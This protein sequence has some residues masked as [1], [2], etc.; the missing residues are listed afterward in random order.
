MKNSG[1]TLIELMIVVVIVSI[2]TMI[3]YPSYRDYVLRSHRA[4]GQIAL[5]IC[6]ATQERW[7]TKNNKYSNTLAECSGSSSEGYYTIS[8]R[9]GDLQSNGSCNQG[10]GSNSDCFLISVSPSTKSNQDED[11]SCSI[12]T[13]DT[14]NA[15]TASDVDGA[16]TRETC[17]RS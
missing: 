12:M 3:A 8:I 16:D 14:T 2:I 6:A 9:V 5:T 1:Y 11:S 15:K 10:A 17:W 7:F 4:D 13:L